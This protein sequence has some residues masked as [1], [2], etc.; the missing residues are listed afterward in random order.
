MNDEIDGADE[1][2]QTTGK[3]QLQTS[4]RASP[5]VVHQEPALG[6]SYIRNPD[7]GDL[8]KQ[9]PDEEQPEQE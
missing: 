7:T 6:G 1:A 9:E 3:G 5:E 2:L 8:V 4:A